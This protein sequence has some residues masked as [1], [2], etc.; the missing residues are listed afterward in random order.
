VLRGRKALVAVP[1]GAIL[2]VVVLLVSTLGAQAADI[3]APGGTGGGLLAGPPGSPW[4]MVVG[5]STGWSLGVQMGILRDRFDVSVANY[6][7]IGCGP[8]YALG[9][10]LNLEDNTVSD[11][12][13]C[14]SAWGAEVR[15]VRPKVV[16]VLFGFPPVYPV[17]IAGTYSHAC[18]PAYDNALLQTL[19][20]EVR[21]MRRPGTRIV[22]MTTPYRASTGLIVYFPDYSDKY[23]DC[24][25]QA[26]R[27]IA[28]S[29][30]ASVLDTNQLLCPDGLRCPKEIDGEPVRADGLHFRSTDGPIV[31]RWVLQHVLGTA[32]T[33][34]SG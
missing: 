23:V 27:E 3:S 6:G 25:N 1:L 13:T 22:V 34:P 14:G 28:S 32:A 29:A 16:I 7:T 2:A 5:D 20:S 19:G 30:G 4:V 17:S 26:L 15:R 31:V 18:Q 33:K 10:V 24:Q 11:P 9:T 21:S 8:L 12:Q